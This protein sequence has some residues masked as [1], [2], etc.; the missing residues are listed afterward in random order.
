MTTL[1]TPPDDRHR[2]LDALRVSAPVFRDEKSATFVLTRY[3]DARALLSDSTLWKDADRAES[4]AL[5]RTFKPA[6]MNRPGDRDSGIGWM[7]DPE[8]ARV[9]PPIA[10]ALG[11]R[12][13]GLRPFIEGVVRGRLDALGPRFDVVADFA[14]PIPIAVIGLL[15][16]VDTADMP[17]FRAW[18]EA[19]IGVFA[20]DPSAAERAATKEAANAITDYLDAAMTL[21]RREKRDDLISDLLAVQAAGGALSDSEIRVNCMNLLLGGNVTTADLIAS[22]IFLLTSHP[23]ER[24]KLIA[25]PAL[26]AGAIEEVLR[27][28]PPTDGSQRVAS[29]DMQIRGC[30]IRQ[31]QVVA[32]MTHAANRDPAVFP[33][34]HRFDISRRDGPHIS[35]G[36]GAHICIG[37]ALARL[38]A[39][40]AVAGMIARFPNLR[41]ADPAPR[42]RAMPFFRG[43]ETLVVE[44]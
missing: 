6:D 34:P 11:R 26:I 7:D 27:Y 17:R 10:L 28:E 9:R 2:M 5:V 42:W 35:F 43:L 20:P 44:S 24:A 16:G 37:A 22:A 3:A 32:V 19:S 14:L 13:A 23:D 36:G 29:R 1:D 15:L 30:P 12:V 40:V 31:S 33:D 39:Q 8:H 4:R 25:D 41:L 21:R 38:E 18:S